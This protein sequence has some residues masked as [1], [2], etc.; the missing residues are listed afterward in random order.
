M[1]GYDKLLF[2]RQDLPKDLLCVIC[3][4]VLKEPVN[5]KTCLLFFCQSCTEIAFFLLIFFP[6]LKSPIK[7]VPISINVLMNIWKPTNI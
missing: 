7:V 6:F 4:Q 5:C 2:L 3:L 1:P